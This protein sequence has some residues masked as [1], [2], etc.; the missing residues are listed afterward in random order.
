MTG[1]SSKNPFADLPE[2]FV[3]TTALSSSVST[4]LKQ[5][6][7]RKLG[8]KV[9]T[10]NLRDTP[11]QVV[12][13]NR[14]TLVASLV[15]GAL[16]VDRT[17]L[18]NLPADDGS[19]FVVADRKRDIELPG[20]VIR[21]R[22]GAPPLPSDRPFIGGLWL[23]SDARAYLDNLVPSRERGRV[24]RTLTVEE[25][26]LHLEQ[27]LRIQEE[28]GLNKLRD[29][30]RQ[31]AP[32][33]GRQAE[34]LELD[35]LIGA[36]L[37]TRDAP[38]STAAGRARR[39]G[40]PFDSHR[41]K[42]FEALRD[43][44][45][46][47][48]PPGRPARDLGREGQSTLE[49]FEAYFSN[50][51]EGTKFEV[52]KAADIVFRG[53]VPVE[54][55]GDAHDILGTWRLVSDSLEMTRTPATP[56]DLFELLRHRHQI[57]MGGRPEVRPGEFKR[58]PNQAGATLFVDPQLVL[59]TL[60]RGLEVQRSLEQ[61]FARA[62]FMM[63]LIAEVHPFADGNGRIARIMM[64]AEL[65]AAGEV[66]VVIPTVYR[67]NYLAAL[68]ALSRNGD[69]S[70][71]LPVLDFAQRWVDAIP[72]GDLEATRAVL[73]GCNAFLESDDEG[74]LRLPDAAT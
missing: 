13:K 10:R 12:R 25:L 30:A 53:E 66:R 57:L 17:A 42:L 64:N 73:D 43:R 9:Y 5:G 6:L 29:E 67:G 36:L 46:E 4:G 34:F 41:F 22:K 71:L 54:R 14:W 40:L 33:I 72:W 15:P 38:L 69:T 47:H 63:F 32:L 21:P 23:S 49:F 8:P 51:I 3:S 44:L 74:R 28:Y 24:R 1:T 52:E 37:G 58:E 7:L 68:K 26:E 50:Y 2:V 11:E 39:A 16:I 20:L 70:S 45:R 61:P 62:A 55:P 48:P 31:I 56:D 59:G 18:T 65:V 27:R 19:V 35:R 60:A